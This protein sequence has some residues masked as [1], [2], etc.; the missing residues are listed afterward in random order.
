MD[1]NANVGALIRFLLFLII[2]KR[3]LVTIMPFV[4]LSEI[5]EP[6]L[7]VLHFRAVIFLLKLNITRARCVIEKQKLSAVGPF[8][9]NRQLK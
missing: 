2:Y 4:I 5:A 6:F 9:Y 1:A 3:I 7:E 8:Q